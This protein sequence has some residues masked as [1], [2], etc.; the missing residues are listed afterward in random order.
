MGSFAAR[1]RLQRPTTDD[2]LFVFTRP[3]GRRVP[4]NGEQCFRGNNSTDGFEETLRE[5]GLAITAETAR[6]QWHGERMDYSTAIE[7]MHFLDSKEPRLTWASPAR[8]HPS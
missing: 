3:D 8:A 1:G 4:D 6:C 5:K 7:A 2:G